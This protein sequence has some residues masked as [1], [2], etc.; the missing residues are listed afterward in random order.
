MSKIQTTPPVFFK[1]PRYLLRKHNILQIIDDLKPKTFADVGCGAGELAVTLAERGFKGVGIDFSDD[2]LKV[3]ESIKESRDVPNDAVKFIKGSL[4]VLPKK[5]DV[6]ICCEVIEH[7]EDDNSFLEEIKPYGEYFIFSVPARMKWFDRFDEK[8]GHYRRYEKDELIEQ[9]IEHGYQVKEF[10]SYGY[11]Y[12]NITRLIRKA[13]AGKVKNQTSLEESTKQS[14]IN[15]I[16]TKWL[17]KMDIEPF[18]KVLYKL[19]TPFNR[20]NLSEGYIVVCEKKN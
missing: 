12:I 13:L 18:M 11:P 16:K 20:Y 10:L 1:A 4:S 2:A 3:A 17:Q 8:V 15:P 14:G 19:S 6:V 9:L 7:L 5:S